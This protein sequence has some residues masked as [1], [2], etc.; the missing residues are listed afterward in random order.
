MLRGDAT[1]AEG[2]AW[3]SWRCMH[4]PTSGGSGSAAGS[5]DGQCNDQGNASQG[6]ASQESG[7]GQSR[8]EQTSL[9][10]DAME[11][12]AEVDGGVLEVGEGAAGEV[13]EGAA[14]GV[15]EVG[16]EAGGEVGEGAG[17]VV[18]EVGGD[19]RELGAYFA[20][21]AEVLRLERA[22]QL[23]DAAEH[24]VTKES[25]SGRSDLGSGKSDLEVAFAEAISLLSAAGEAAARR[26]L[27][28]GKPHSMAVSTKYGK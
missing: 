5:Q 10:E 7:A 6:N 15:P 20:D 4:A 2:G 28:A 17:G 9:L 11:V 18:L 23:S 27:H 14:G 8:A 13:G 24:A 22:L 25:T 1:P 3:A 12:G 19:V 26:L 21:R 16:A